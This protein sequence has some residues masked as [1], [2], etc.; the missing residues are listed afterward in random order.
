V[1]NAEHTNGIVKEEVINTGFEVLIEVAVFWYVS[2]CSAVDVSETHT[3]SVFR[4]EEEAK[5]TARSEESDNA[6]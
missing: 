5:Q 1:D 2:P 3:A 6:W 4:I